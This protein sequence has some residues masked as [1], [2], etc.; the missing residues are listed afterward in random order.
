MSKKIIKQIKKEYGALFIK[1]A[2]DAF[3]KQQFS[4]LPKTKEFLQFVLPKYLLQNIDLDQLQESKDSFV[5]EK[6]RENFSDLLFYNETKD[7]ILYILYEH[8]S[9]YDNHTP[10]QI[11]RYIMRIWSNFSLNNDGEKLPMILPIVLYHGEESWQQQTDIFNLLQTEDEAYRMYEN[12]FS[13][14]S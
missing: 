8:K 6:L 5:D 13:L 4:Q 12:Y 11:L 1:N 14:T 9:T 2:H 3:F 7:T 10:L